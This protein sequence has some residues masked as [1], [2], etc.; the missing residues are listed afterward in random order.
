MKLVNIEKNPNIIFNKQ[1][2]KF[3]NPDYIYIPNN[4]EITKTYYK[5]NENIYN[6]YYSSISGKVIKNNKYIQI[7]NDYKEKS[8]IIYKNKAKLTIDRIIEATKSNEKLF[9]KFNGLRNC[10]NIVISTINDEIYVLNNIIL[11]KENLTDI[12]DMIDELAKA[13]DSKNNILVIKNND[14]EIIDDFFNIMGTY[15]NIK[16]TLVEDK[17]LIGKEEILLNK[18]KLEN[19]KTIF[20]T[21]ED[22]INLMQL[23]KYGIPSDRKI[24]TISGDAIKQSIIIE[25]KKYVMIKEIIDKYIQ[26]I[27]NN[28][29]LYK[30]NLLEENQI[31]ITDIITEDIISLHL[32]KTKE[33]LESQCTNC[34]MCLK[35]CPMGINIPKQLKTGKVNSKCI[36]CGICNYICPS[37]INI[38]KKIAGDKNDNA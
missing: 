6:N 4:K 21:I 9:S 12:L 2:K 32:M 22:I 17:Y 27:D 26:I 29:V 15:S 5:K 38:S 20:L 10:E 33:Y 31:N 37:Y 23:L 3:L 8:K 1:L 24:I 34:G 18:L 14:T 30:N 36:N 16:L 25:V 19:N 13:Y 35:V 11:L 7:E 28:Y